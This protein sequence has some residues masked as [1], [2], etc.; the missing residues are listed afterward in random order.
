MKTETKYEQAF[1]HNT[2]GLQFLSVGA[3]PGCRE[4][5]LETR[6]ILHPTGDEFE[7]EAEARGAMEPGDTLEIREPSEHDRERAEEAGFSWSECDFC[8]CTLGGSRYPAHAILADT[9]ADAQRPGRKI[10]HF[11]VC[12]DCLQYVANGTLPGESD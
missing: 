7:T 10:S 3:C 9:P 4:C 2:R 11:Q 1:N 8:G 5:G 6:F 12:E